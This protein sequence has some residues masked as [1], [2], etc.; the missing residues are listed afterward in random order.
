M[1]YPGDSVPPKMQG[2]GGERR[3]E[4]THPGSSYL[5]RP[6]EC[7]VRCVVRRQ[8]DDVGKL[9]WVA[10]G[11]PS[12]HLLCLTPIQ[13]D[14]SEDRKKRKKATHHLHAGVE[15]GRHRLSVYVPGV[16]IPRN[17]HS[18]PNPCFG[19]EIE[20]SLCRRIVVLD[21]EK[22]LPAIPECVMGPGSRRMFT[23]LASIPP[24]SG[25]T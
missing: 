14:D 19:Q 23:I 16:G 5:R 20:E 8:D 25:A 10:S 18:R 15:F 13:H 12:P 21:A 17:R 11:E 3:S 9:L 6:D 22:S 7:L 4:V 2:G 1:P 24:W